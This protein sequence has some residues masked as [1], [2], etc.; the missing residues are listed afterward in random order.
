[1]LLAAATGDSRRFGQVWRWTA[2]HLRTPDGLLSWHWDG[3]HVIDAQPAS[4]ADLDA[5]RALLVAAERFGVAGY[6]HEALR[7]A[8]GVL[9]AETVDAAGR[10]TLVAG[11]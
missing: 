5:A 2:S 1:M 8:D 4:D 6:R 9:G 11:P 3:G 7:I 10:P